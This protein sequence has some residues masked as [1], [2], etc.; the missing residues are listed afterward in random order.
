MPIKLRIA[1]ITLGEAPGLNR[2]AGLKLTSSACYH[3]VSTKP[4]TLSHINSSRTSPSIKNH[5]NSMRVY[6]YDKSGVA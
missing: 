4:N 3:P 5:I 6:P 1:I 2:E